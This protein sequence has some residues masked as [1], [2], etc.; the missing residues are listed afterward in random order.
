MYSL[1]I[2][3]SKFFSIFCCQKI[4]KNKSQYINKINKIYT[5]KKKSQLFWQ[6]TNKICWEKKHC[7]LEVVINLIMY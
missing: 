2:P 3:G 7:K 5:R 6:K 4:E 1:A